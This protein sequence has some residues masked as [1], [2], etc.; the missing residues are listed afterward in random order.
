MMSDYGDFCREQ[1][2][3]REQKKHPPIKYNKELTVICSCGKKFYAEFFPIKQE[4]SYHLFND[5]ENSIKRANDHIMSKRSR[6]IKTCKLEFL[7]EGV[8]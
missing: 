5:I 4:K 3:Y 7:N 6:G 8:E 2:E 1:R